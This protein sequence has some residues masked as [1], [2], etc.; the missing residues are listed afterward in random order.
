MAQHLAIVIPS[1]L[2]RTPLE[3]DKAKESLP[4]AYCPLRVQDGWTGQ[5]FHL[6]KNK[7]VFDG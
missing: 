5:C 4:A 7:E 2:P 3:N 1:P 6:G